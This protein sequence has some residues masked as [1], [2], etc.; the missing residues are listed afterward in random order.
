MIACGEGVSCW[1]SLRTVVGLAA[2]WY[3]GGRGRWEGEGGRMSSI[4]WGGWV[5]VVFG[6]EERDDMNKDGW[7]F[8]QPNG[9]NG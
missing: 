9:R 2:L 1:N 6:E 5:M 3:G 4:M 8:S 7:S